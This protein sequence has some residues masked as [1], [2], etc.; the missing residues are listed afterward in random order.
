MINLVVF[1]VN[2]ASLGFSQMQ[3]QLQTPEAQIL[4]LPTDSASVLVH[5][6]LD[7]S[8]RE[9]LA[10]HSTATNRHSLRALWDLDGDYWDIQVNHSCSVPCRFDASDDSREKAHGI[11]FSAQLFPAFSHFANVMDQVLILFLLLL[12]I[13]F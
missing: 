9:Q 3:G 4:D 10:P 5:V 13:L 6:A 7:S 2:L 1:A 11:L 12:L 8:T